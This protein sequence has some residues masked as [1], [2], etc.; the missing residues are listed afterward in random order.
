MNSAGITTFRLF[1]SKFGSQTTA[2]LRFASSATFETHDYKLHHLTEAPSKKATVTSEEAKD[3]Y[4]KMQTIRKLETE[5]GALYKEK[6]IRGFCHLYTGEEACAVG[7]HAAMDPNDAVITSYRC[8]GLAYL[9]RNNVTEILSEMTGR[10]AGNVYGKGG[11][12]HM[13]AK[14]FFGGNGIV[15]A[16]VPLGAGAAFALKY[17]NQKN[18]CFA[19]Y[20]DGAANQGQI[21]EA[22]NMAE[23]WQIPVI[24]V[25][26]NNGYGMGMKATRSSA[27]T[28][29]YKRGDFV[30]GIWVD[31][32]DI[33]SVREGF[34]Y[35]KD[36]CNSGKGPIVVE[37]NTYRYVGHSTIEKRHGYRTEEEI[38]DVRSHRDC[39]VKFR[40]QCVQSKIVSAEEF[41]EID[42]NVHDEV[43]KAVKIAREDDELPM[44]GLYTDLYKNTPPQVVRGAT[45]FESVKQPFVTTSELVEKQL[46]RKPVIF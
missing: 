15:G 45:P 29:Y 22:F 35:A 8:H 24:F 1:A 28:E 39:I 34:K 44:E 27:S 4:K 23:L 13:Y 43:T 7:L 30:P 25:C 42:K 46:K 11:S 14:H 16:Q 5:A 36:F 20:G 33:L 37:L 19:L 17:R 41:K 38:Q 21:S 18:V 2:P 3:Y 6:R 9:L 32:M 40:E 31:G 10:I 26:E 12:M